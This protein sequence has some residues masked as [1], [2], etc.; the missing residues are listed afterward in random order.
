MGAASEI[1]SAPGQTS[2]D[3]GGNFQPGSA[4]VLFFT[5][6]DIRGMAYDPSDLNIEIFDPTGTS[7]ET[8]TN[9]D[10]IELGVFGYTWNIPTTA[11]SGKYRAVLSYVIQTIEGP[12]TNTYEQSFVV[13][14]ECFA[15]VFSYRQ[16]VCRALLESLVG[17]TQRIPVFNE[18]IR[19]NRARTQGELSFPRWNHTAG[20]KLT[21]NDVP[22]ESGY[23]VDYAKGWITFDH[24][25]PEHDEV[26]CSYNFRWFSDNDI[27]NF[28]DMGLQ[29]INI[30]PPQLNWN[31]LNVPPFWVVAVEYCAAVN[32]IRSWMM[33]LAFQEP[34]KVF[35]GLK[36]AQEVF[37]QMD[38]LKKNFEERLDKM[39]EQKKNFSYMGL[40]KTITVPEYTLPGGRSR[41]FRY[42]Y[43]S[44]V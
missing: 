21:V 20:V 13:V 37:Q 33:A 24:S 23:T 18:I 11:V 5:F 31:L 27:D 22:R 34:A 26:K 15:T 44:G 28:I 40:T 1:I 17:Y 7:V 14:E 3:T 36:R 29:E 6:T 30:W 2:F 4:A 8:G 39:L 16:V 10:R 32:L 19:F 42:L 35:G 41:W 9:M 38:T 12:V 25:V 43:K